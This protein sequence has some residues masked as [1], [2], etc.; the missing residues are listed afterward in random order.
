MKSKISYL[1]G[2]YPTQAL[3]NRIAV[4]AITCG[5]LF[6]SLLA[7]GQCSADEDSIREYLAQN[8]T[9]SYL[10]QGDFRIERTE[11]RQHVPDD[12][13]VFQKYIQNIPLHGGRVVVFEEF[14][15]FVSHVYDDSSA[16]LKLKAAPVAME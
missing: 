11:A 9:T 3:Q 10:Q 2:L 16:N 13:M 8:K 14:D 7:S 15:G 6:G 12:V 1:E 5:I 4:S